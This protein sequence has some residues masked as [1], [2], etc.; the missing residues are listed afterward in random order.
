MVPRRCFAARMSICAITRNRHAKIPSPDTASAA[1]DT[2][3][4]NYAP[5][6]DADTMSLPARFTTMRVAVP[7]PPFGAR[8]PTRAAK[9]PSAPAAELFSVSDMFTPRPPLRV[10]AAIRRNGSARYRFIMHHATAPARRFQ[11]NASRRVF[12]R[13]QPNCVSR[14]G[15]RVYPECPANTLREP[16]LGSDAATMI[17]ATDARCIDG[18][19]AKYSSLRL[20]R[21]FLR[22]SH[23]V[24]WRH[25]VRRGE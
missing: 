3:D 21:P 19:D 8:L 13:E 20:S 15:F 6:A 4:G 12:R 10:H 25:V 17:S 2:V 24:R 1:R 11:E 18:G 16:R 5:A 23:M 14:H 22:D 9:M 7:P